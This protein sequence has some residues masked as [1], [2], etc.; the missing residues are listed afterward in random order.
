MKHYR[1]EDIEVIT[2]VRFA[3]PDG[4]VHDTLA[5]ALAHTPPRRVTYKMWKPDR[6][7]GI[8]PAGLDS[9]VFLFLSD[10]DS[11]QDFERDM[12]KEDFC[13]DGIEEPGWYTWSHTLFKWEVMSDDVRILLEYLKSEE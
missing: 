12:H 9:C 8:V 5:E 7:I 6:E 2:T 1:P 13:V 4:E 10:M 11:V 3:T